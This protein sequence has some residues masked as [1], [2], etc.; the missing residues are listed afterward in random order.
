MN[1]FVNEESVK[2]RTVA[3]TLRNEETQST[4][5]ATIV[6]RDISTHTKIKTNKNHVNTIE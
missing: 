2:E 3:N 5:D 1:V 6:N 4:N